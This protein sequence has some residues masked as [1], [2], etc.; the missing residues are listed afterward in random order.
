ME[1]KLAI[2]AALA[3]LLFDQC[4]KETVTPSLDE[5]TA[6][7]EKAQQFV[8]TAIPATNFLLLYRS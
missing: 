8:K 5:K 7:L 3:A 2:M 4:K 6:F 1:A